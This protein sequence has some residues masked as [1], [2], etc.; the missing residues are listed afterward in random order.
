VVG[1]AL[2]ALGWLIDPGRFFWS[3]LF[4]YL[5]WWGIALGCLGLALLQ[6]L[7]GG[8][9][10]VVTRRTFEAGVRTLP[11]LVVL[12]VPLLFGLRELYPWARME[13][14]A[15]DPLLRYKSPYLNIPFFLA[16]AAIYFL[17]W[18][19]LG[20]FLARWSAEQDRTADPRLARNLR[21][22]SAGGLILLGVSASFAAIDWAMSLEPDWY[23]TIY[24]AMVGMG[25][26]LAAFALAVVVV[27]LL[28]QREPFAELTTPG[29]FNDLGSL[30]LAFLM[31]W[32]YLA[33]SQLLLIWSGNLTEEVPWYLRRIAG[34][35]YWV[36]LFVG[37]GGF[38]VPFLLLIFRDL[39][40]DARTLAPIAGWVILAHL[41]VVYWLVLPAFDPAGLRPHWLDVAA[42]VGVGG[43]WLALFARLLASRPLL[44]P[45]DH[46]LP[47][48][49][50]R[51]YG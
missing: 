17:S 11:L 39:K 49:A 21:R 35:W 13:D 6:F 33:F 15:A 44:P 40:R 7:T 48:P 5:F 3:Y 27:T 10:G 28:G 14:V 30:L 50:E 32:A 8:A 25:A 41:V 31:L 42:P 51:A 2:S 22:L 36:A 12:F 1:L 26:V 24:P 20:Y 46:R 16:R 34:G 45:H 29:L 19:A 37:V 23:S 43:L 18:L 38:A 47:E 4:G 9:W